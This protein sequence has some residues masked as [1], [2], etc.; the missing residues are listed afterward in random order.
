MWDADLI[1]SITMLPNLKFTN[2]NNFATTNKPLSID[3]SFKFDPVKEG[4][5][6]RTHHCAVQIRHQHELGAGLGPHLRG[7][8]IRS[9]VLLQGNSEA[10]F[11]PGRRGSHGEPTRGGAIHGGVGQEEAQ[12]G[13]KRAGSGEREGATSQLGQ[14]ESGAGRG[15][16]GHEADVLLQRRHGARLLGLGQHGSAGRVRNWH[17]RL[18]L[19]HWCSRDGA[20]LSASR[21]CHVAHEQDI[22]C[23]VHRCGVQN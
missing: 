12:V 1:F 14:G 15:A 23:L 19:A 3:P 20:K 6:G 5:G 22:S 8:H 13:V 4:E 21:L 2:S 9:G 10:K 11:P 17:A 18:R 16:D 7:R